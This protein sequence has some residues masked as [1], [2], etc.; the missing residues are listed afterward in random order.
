[1]TNLKIFNAPAGSGKST[2]IKDRV[3]EWSS[4]FPQD[5]MLCVTYTNRA[6]GELKSGISA[7]NVDVSTIHS[8][9][10]E[11]MIPV[12]TSPEAVSLYLKVYKDDIEA[13]LA[14]VE[15]KDHIET[16][17]ARYREKLGEPL[18]F[19][20]I[21]SSIKSLR[22]NEMQFNSLFA[23]GLSHDD[24]L[25]FTG[26]CAAHFPG[27]RKR[28]S[29]KYQQI[30]IDEYQDTSVEVLE[31]FVDAVGDSNSS[32]HLYGDPMQ[33]IYQASSIRLRSVLAQFE[34][35]NQTVTNYRSSTAIVDSLNG[36]YNDPMLQQKANN[37]ATSAP[38]RIHLTSDPQ[39]LEVKIADPETLV[40][41]VRNQTIFDN[42]GAS[43]LLKA[44]QSMDDH[45]Y[46]SRYRAVDVLREP[47]WPD[48]N[49]P[50]IQLLF[51][52]LWIEDTYQQD[53]Y[54]EVIQ[55][56]RK[57][58]S[59]FGL[60]PVE[61]HADKNRL[62]SELEGLFTF[63][64]T[65]GVSIKEIVSHLVS[66][67]PM[68]SSTVGEYLE[69]EDYNS[70]LSVPFIQARKMY[71]FNQRPRWSTQHGVKGES[72]E[73]VIFLAEDS[74]GTPAVHVYKLFKLWPKIS[75]NLAT[76]DE[77][78]VEVSALFEQA[79]KKAAGYFTKPN[80][81]TY[82]EHAEI[83]TAEAR[84]VMKACADLPLF[85]ALYGEVFE[86][87]LSK[88]HT[89][90]AKELFKMSTIEGLLTAYRLFYVGCSRA[91]NDLDVIVDRRKID[92][93]PAFSRKLDDLGFEVLVHE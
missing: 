56:L 62:R 34:T 25:S 20:L 23:G 36:I 71:H 87:Y 64:A 22:Y 2:E 57:K 1:M 82:D 76:L 28:I 51:G 54:G 9:L 27:L 46:S 31:F 7:D 39:S 37:K 80:K 45:G 21:A 10:A 77:T 70:L 35:E 78:Y 38:P 59:V 69:N 30:I 18:T 61:D 53:K 79:R 85:G 6:A 3:R 47:S 52:L 5:R 63:M 93:E 17:N 50:L 12:F 55:V 4:R 40:L 42:I 14:N 83:I 67:G 15:K 29:A 65:D 75:F 49:N 48:V 43:D 44:V 91:R 84:S 13:R 66:I 41:S 11:F 89:S 81:A 26:V 88:L 33:Q 74:T 92:D 16:S 32:L 73:K 60:L 19:E 72:H 86:T 58:V 24:L 8:F 90:S 68:K